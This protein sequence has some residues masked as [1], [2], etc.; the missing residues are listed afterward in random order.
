MAP[1]WFGQNDRQQNERQIVAV[2]LG[3]GLSGLS[4]AIENVKSIRYDQIP[5]LASTTAA[6]HR[7]AFLLG[8]LGESRIIAMAGRLHAYEGHCLE[9]L[10]RPMKLMASLNPQA[11]IVSCAAGGLNPRFAEGDVA[12]ID[13]HISFLHGQIGGGLGPGNAGPGNEPNGGNTP[14]GEVAW[15]ANRSGLPTCDVR[16]AELAEK[17]AR[18]RQFA[19]RRG[20]YLATTGP[21]Y[22]TRAECRM[23][24]TW[25][26]DLVGMSTVPEVVWASRLGLRT[27]AVGVVTN[28]AVPDAPQTA[29]H[30]DVLAVSSAAGE[31]LEHIVRE[32]ANHHFEKDLRH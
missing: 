9:T 15:P 5:G 12:L 1:G 4:D 10:T 2:V 20:T 13:E 16:L 17:A 14:S 24:R 31:K 6:G 32:I 18:E 26:I 7:G 29:N 8:N 22:E 3:S 19:L 28:M 11:V 25:G 23:M 30:E 21:T 27:L